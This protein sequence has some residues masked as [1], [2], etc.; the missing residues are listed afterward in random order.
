MGAAMSAK[1][2]RDVCMMTVLVIA[3]VVLRAMLS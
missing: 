1:V 3:L 2:I